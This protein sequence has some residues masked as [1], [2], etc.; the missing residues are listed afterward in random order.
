[1]CCCSP[2]T[3][4]LLSVSQVPVFRTALPT[5]LRRFHLGCLRSRPG[6]AGSDGRAVTTSA[7]WAKGVQGRP[8]ARFGRMRHRPPRLPAHRAC[9]QKLPFY[10]IFAADARCPRDG[11]HLEQLGWYDPAP[12]ESCPRR[13]C[14]R[15]LPRS[16]VGRS[17][18]L[19]LPVRAA[20]DGNKHL[21]LNIER[22]K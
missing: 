22:I 12:G 8:R 19:S 4:I 21:G 17:G 1:M 9:P 11:R 2:R 7:V 10:R 20:Q 16:P 3:S 6:A 18:T 14:R 5:R 15:L 13:P